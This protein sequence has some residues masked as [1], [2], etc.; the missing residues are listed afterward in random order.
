MQGACLCWLTQ[1]PNRYIYVW[2]LGWSYQRRLAALVGELF[3]IVGLAVAVGI[4]EES[5]ESSEKN[6]QKGRADE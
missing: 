1:Q 3:G 2:L 4:R 5:G 6:S